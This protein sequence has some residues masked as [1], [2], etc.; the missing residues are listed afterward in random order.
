MDSA[1]PAWYLLYMTNNATH[2]ANYDT[3]EYLYEVLFPAYLAAADRH[4]AADPDGYPAAYAA[5]DPRVRL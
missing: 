3:E 5:A 4:R 2:P 1:T